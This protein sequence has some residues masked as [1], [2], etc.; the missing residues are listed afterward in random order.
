MAYTSTRISKPPSSSMGGNKR[1]YSGTPFP[2]DLIASEDKGEQWHLLYTKAIYGSWRYGGNNTVF[3]YGGVNFNE[4][5]RFAQGTQSVSPLKQLLDCD[6]DEDYLNLDWSPVKILP[7]FLDIIY[8]KINK[9]RFSP[10][11]DAIDPQSVEKKKEAEYSMNARLKLRDYM[12][13]LNIL[14]GGNMFPEPDADNFI[15]QNDQE[16]QMWMQMNYKMAEEI[17][18][19]EGIQVALD[20]ND[21]LEIMKQV[22]EDIYE[23]GYGGTKVF[24]NDRNQI[25]I[26]RVV[27]ERFIVGPSER[28]NFRDSKYFAEILKLR[29]GD[30]K[31]MD[32]EKKI[33]EDEWEEIARKASGKFGNT[34]GFSSNINESGW[35]KTYNN[36]YIEVLDATWQSTDRYE[37]ESFVNEYGNQITRRKKRKGKNKKTEDEFADF[38][39]WYGSLWI[40]GTDHVLDWGRKVSIPVNKTNPKEAKPYFNMYAPWIRNGMITCPVE[41]AKQFVNNLMINWLKAQNEIA[42]AAPAGIAIEVDALA[43]IIDPATEKQYSALE[44]VEMFKK[45]GVQLYRS[46]GDEG[47][48]QGKPFEFNENGLPSNFKYYLDMINFNIGMLREVTGINKIADASTPH[49]RQGLGTSQMAL[50]ATQ[51]SM[52]TPVD[53]IRNILTETCRSVGFQLQ[54]LARDG[55]LKPWLRAI[56]MEAKAQKITGDIAYPAFGINVEALPTEQDRRELE[57]DIKIALK[58]RQQGSGSGIKQEDAIAIR[59]MENIKAA[60]QLIMYRR[61]IREEEYQRKQQKH[62]QQQMKEKQMEIMLKAKADVIKTTSK[63]KGEA[64]LKQLQAQI[65]L[66]QD[67]MK[68]TNDLRK[69]VIESQLRKQETGSEKTLELQNEIDKMEKEYELEISKIRELE[70]MKDKMF[71]E[72]GEEVD[73][74]IDKE[75]LR[76]GIAGA[77]KEKQI[78]TD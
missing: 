22:V 69:Q 21:Y 34:S 25:E 11:A 74:S 56:G 40:V 8:G 73:A 72:L 12:E 38:E 58:E 52:E 29:I 55:Y 6:E 13:D 44:L 27:P 37:F 28:K 77:K 53:G 62:Y 3:G 5:R 7:K 48:R 65:D 71:E 35:D 26:R 4:N 60:E 70:Q 15:P 64:K 75:E 42:N 50:Q 36:F 76:K 39:T 61:R 59:R 2:S 51:D 46:T 30:L 20:W 43:N 78:Q 32:V 9:L 23:I 24:R 14:E 57:G 67:K 63:T 49:P 66:R 1:G 68:Y 18:M 54:E 47:N 31:A 10:V 41:R 19:E 45:K 16:L 33:T 17:A